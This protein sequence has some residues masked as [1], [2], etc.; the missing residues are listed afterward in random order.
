M[1]KNG[2]QRRRDENGERNDADFDAAQAF[3]ADVDAGS[4][5]KMR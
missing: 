1:S 4:A 3:S 5:K 2:A